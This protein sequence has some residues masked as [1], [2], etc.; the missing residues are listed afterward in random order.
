MKVLLVED[1]LTLGESLKE[2]LELNDITVKW[3]SDDREVEDV[4]LTESF[5]VIVLDLI[6]KYQRGEDILKNLRGRGINTPVLVLTA[7]KALR[8]KEVC[9]ERGADDYLTKPF[10]P[11]EL[12]LRLQALTR[13][14]QRNKII[15][16]GKVKIN[17]EA[18]TVYRGEEEIKL[19]RK[20]W[21]LLSFLL[22]HRGQII[23]KERILNYVWANTPV[24]DEIIRTYIKDLRKS[25]PELQ[26]ETYKGRGYRLK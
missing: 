8:D 9:F 21:E 5:D 15:V 2:Y 7:K 20:A 13:R 12:L 3:L 24:G 4:F 26:I 17:L 11:K 6:L 22:K 14:Q 1:D 10:A 18:E 23:P 19:S 16:I 25:L